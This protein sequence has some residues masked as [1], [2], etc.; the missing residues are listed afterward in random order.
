M[1]Y[2]FISRFFAPKSGI[3][4][5]PVTGSSFTRLV[6]YLAEQSGRDQ[7]WRYHF[8]NDWP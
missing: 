2:D 4:E 8:L 7:H 3:D 6:P 5:N 1:Q